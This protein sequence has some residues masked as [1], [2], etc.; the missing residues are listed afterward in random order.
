MYLDYI[1]ASEMLPKDRIPSYFAA[2]LKWR[3]LFSVSYAIEFMSLSVAKLLVLDRM[4][5][6]YKNSLSVDLH[7]RLITAGRAVVG[8]VI[9]GCAVGT[10]GNVAAAVYFKQSADF[11]ETSS[12]FY[13]SNYTQ[14]GDDS[15]SAATTRLEQALYVNHVTPPPPLPFQ[16]RLCMTIHQVQS[17]CE[18]IVLLIIITAFAI[19]GGL[20]AR[21]IS[22]SL[23]R[24]RRNDD[25]VSA[26][27]R[28]LRLRIIATV[29]FVFV[30]F[31]LRAVFATMYTS[32][33]P[34]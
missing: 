17:L 9:V 31:L 29:A 33:S 30:T 28:S 32:K 15:F 8:A 26:S 12:G 14:D 22:A 1:F 4:S 3:A 19:V 16:Q 10:A 13:T 23:Q 27:G 25:V 21:H 11:Y 18:V 2:A 34:R 7:P 24:L 6:F 5:D 20:C